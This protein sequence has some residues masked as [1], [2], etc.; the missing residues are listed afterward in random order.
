M[1]T[2]I[3]T[4]TPQKAA[5]ILERNMKNNR[6]VKQWQVA[7]L[8]DVIKR[9][10]WMLNGESI[11][12]DTNGDLQDGQHR[13][14]ACVKAGKPIETVVVEGVEPECYITQNT[15]TKQGLRDVLKVRSVQNY[16]YVSTIISSYIFLRDYSVTSHNIGEKATN[17]QLY[18]EYLSKWELYDEIASFM[19]K[20][21]SRTRTMP[22]ADI[23]GVITLLIA[24]RYYPK[25]K[26]FAFFD[27]V[28][29]YKNF[30]NATCVTMREVLRRDAESDRKMPKRTRMHYYYVALRHY[31]AGREVKRLYINDDP[32]N[33]NDL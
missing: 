20:I 33:F 17:S 18:A 14:L 10:E 4:I 3:A 7:Q 29:D 23:G 25:E 5:R 15:G 9:G 13:L 11:K 1:K 24:D 21:I 31:L 30:D 28:S 16:A 12:I 32:F 26:I 6:N 8:A 19:R 22:L 27:M 2:Y